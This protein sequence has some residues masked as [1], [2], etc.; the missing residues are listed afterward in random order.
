LYEIKDVKSDAELMKDLKE[1]VHNIAKQL[2]GNYGIARFGMRAV[3]TPPPEPSPEQVA[4][5]PK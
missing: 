3:S 4:G 2:Q 1:K 5:L